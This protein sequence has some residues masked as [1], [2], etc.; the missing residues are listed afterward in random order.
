[1]AE[2]EPGIRRLCI[3][4]AAPKPGLL[5]S[6]CRTGEWDRLYVLADPR[7]GIETAVAPPGVDEVGLVRDLVRALRREVW[8]DPESPGQT[9][10]VV[11]VGIVRIVGD[12]FG[13]AGVSR[14]RALARNAAV[15][16][17]ADRGAREQGKATRFAVVISDG[18]FSDLR[19]EGVSGEG[20]QLVPPAAA[21]VRAFDSAASLEEEWT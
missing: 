3:V 18:L 14:T 6:A 17:A 13:G 11:H 16:A 5:T 20:W 7:N 19:T 15:R 21:W 9:F 1:M 12:G 2:I 8:V 4:V 10:L